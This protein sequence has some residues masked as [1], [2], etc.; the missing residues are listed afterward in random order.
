M[1]QEMLLE[2]YISLLIVFFLILNVFSTFCPEEKH[3]FRVIAGKFS[4]TLY[5]P[6]LLATVLSGIEIMHLA[7]GN[8]NKFAHCLKNCHFQ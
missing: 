5:I 1:S 3:A 7:K 6:D 2:L 8:V 4:S